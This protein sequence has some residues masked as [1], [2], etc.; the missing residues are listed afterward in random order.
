MPKI[1]DIADDGLPEL[2]GSFY[3]NARTVK[4]EL[5]SV[6]SQKCMRASLNK[7]FKET[8]N[9]A[10]I[11]DPRFIQANSV[12]DGVKVQAKK[13][14]KATKLI[15]DSDMKKL[16]QYFLQ[17]FNI[18]PVN[19]KKFQQCVLF[20]LIYFTCRRGYVNIHA[21]TL[22]TYSIKVDEENKMCGT[23]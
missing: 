9:I 17:D 8:R 16:G 6:Q 10:I 1:E 14:G 13:E 3:M 23:N 4:R 19:P 11:K 15:I 2:L 7:Y 20:Y 5:Y 12:F 22:D 21:M 18:P